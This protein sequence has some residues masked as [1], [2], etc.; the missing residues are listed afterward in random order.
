M[1]YY[2]SLSEKISVVEINQK[3]QIKG[4]KGYDIK[5]EEIIGS[6]DNDNEFMITI[7]NYLHVV[8]DDSQS[9]FGQLSQITD[10][11]QNI[12]QNN[13]ESQVQEPVKI[14]DILMNS[15]C[16]ATI[17]SNYFDSDD[18]PLMLISWKDIVKEYVKRYDEVFCLTSAKAHL[19]ICDLVVDG[20]KEK[21][22]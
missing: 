9:T 10:F 18:N 6:N 16:V 3:N 12:E 7:P 5:R 1:F 15:S 2:V 21:W 11:S 20:A 22:R 14:I 17:Q 4:E 19:D 13:L 8:T